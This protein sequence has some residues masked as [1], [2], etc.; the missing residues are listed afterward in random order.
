MSD[1]EKR[2]NTIWLGPLEADAA[3]VLAASRNITI[4]ELVE[5]LIREE[6]V[7]QIGRMRPD[8]LP[9]I[10]DKKSES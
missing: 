8:A 1:K 5:A 4:D 10:R 9:Q 2:Q 6:A 7:F 3:R